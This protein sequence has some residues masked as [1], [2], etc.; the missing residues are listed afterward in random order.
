MMQ[1]SLATLTAMTG[2]IYLSSARSAFMALKKNWVLVPA[3]IG[4]LLALQVMTGLLTILPLGM[5]GG[6]ILGLVYLAL[7]TLYISWIARIVQKELLRWKELFEF[8]TSL[9]FGLMSVGFIFFL[10]D[11]VLS[12]LF[13]GIANPFPILCIGILLAVLFNPVTEVVYQHRFESTH[14]LKHSLQFVKDNF[15][16]WF[17]PYFI[18][19]CPFFFSRGSL[20][21]A[22]LLLAQTDP[23]FPLF[24]AVVPWTVV[25]SRMNAQSGSILL[26]PLLFLTIVV[27]AC[28]F[29][30]FRGFLFKELDSG[31]RRTRAFRSRL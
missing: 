17:L 2:K 4:L 5:A 24:Q 23:L 1:P 3:A 16:E 25:A 11:L 9:F 8:D 18:F 28:W 7:L 21:A 19:M 15:I 26:T 10:V 14:A 29:M 27:L 20:E 13:Q 12:I 31:S 6:L 22:V 30:L